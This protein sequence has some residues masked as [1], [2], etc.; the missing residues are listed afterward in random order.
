MDYSQWTMDLTASNRATKPQWWSY[1][2]LKLYAPLEDLSAKSLY[3]LVGRLREDDDLF[4]AYS[5]VVVLSVLRLP[6]AH[7]TS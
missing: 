5:Q 3:N 7:R 4:Q 6:L 2:P 1:S